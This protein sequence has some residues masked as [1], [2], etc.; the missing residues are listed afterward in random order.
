VTQRVEAAVRVLQGIDEL[1]STVTEGSSQ[2]VIQLAIGTPIDRAVND[3]R[4]AIAQVR[5][6]LPEGILEPQVFRANTTATTSR[7][8]GDRDRHDASSSSAGTSTTR[9]PRSCCPSR[10]GGGHRN[11][12]VSRE[13]RVILDP[14][15]C[16]RRA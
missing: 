9:S 6:D 13:I 16:R 2:T 1:N 11:G 15:S 5:G 8:I 14:V 3:V 4:D 12:G 7:A 10:H